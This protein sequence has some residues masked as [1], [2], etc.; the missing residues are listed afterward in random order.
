MKRQMNL[1]CSSVL[2]S[3]IANVAFAAGEVTIARQ[4]NLLAEQRMVFNFPEP[5]SLVEVAKVISSS[6]NKPVLLP[7]NVQTKIQIVMNGAVTPDEAF[8]S[9]TSASKVAG[10]DVIETENHIVLTKAEAKETVT[11]SRIPSKSI[12]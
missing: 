10:F 4:E 9:F 12:N 6:R 7:E 3:F 8:Q 11:N 5:T 2:V 1:F